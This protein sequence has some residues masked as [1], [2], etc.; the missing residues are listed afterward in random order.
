[1]TR[2]KF[3]RLVIAATWRTWLTK[4]RLVIQRSA[5]ARKH[6]E[7]QVPISCQVATSCLVGFFL[8]ARNDIRN[9]EFE[10]RFFA[11]LLGVNDTETSVFTGFLLAAYHFPWGQRRRGR[12]TCGCRAGGGTRG[13][14][15]GCTCSRCRR[16]RCTCTRSGSTRGC[17]DHLPRVGDLAMLATPTFFAVAFILYRSGVLAGPEFSAWIFGAVIQVFDAGFTAPAFRAGTSKGVAKVLTRAVDA[18]RGWQGPSS[19]NDAVLA[20][21]SYYFGCLE[22]AADEFVKVEY[23]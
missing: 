4:Q 18:A 11:Q 9:L 14:G 10:S 19:C 13:R 23:I 6:I 5:W 16:S 20:K 7:L 15:R 22:F 1:M 2:A 21:E 8:V 3:A 12:R 17:C